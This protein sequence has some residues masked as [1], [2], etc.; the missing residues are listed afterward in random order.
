[1]VKHLPTIAMKK[2]QRLQMQ[3]SI[4]HTPLKKQLM[5]SLN[6]Q[7]TL[8]RFIMGTSFR[9]LLCSNESDPRFLMA[10]QAAKNAL[11]PIAETMSALVELKKQGKIRAIGVSNFSV[12]QI[13]EAMQFDPI[14]SVQP[15]YSLF[16]R[17]AADLL[18]PYS[19]GND[20]SILAYSPLAQG[21]LTGKFTHSHRFPE[22][23][24][25]SSHKLCL[26]EHY[27]RVQIALEKLR[28]IALKNAMTLG[29]LALTWL[30][31]QP[32][33][34]AIVG[35]RNPP[36]ILE[37]AAVLHMALS[38]YDLEEINAIGREVTNHLDA[39]PVMWL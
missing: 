22:G 8:L 10:Y 5:N 36:Q 17:Q 21:L 28:P 38:P 18:T 37:N 32:L 24:L 35:A 26:P 12:G 7:T 1:M 15:P 2:L 4:G 34:S 30:I 19:L 16:W 6:I 31:S 39:D 29:Q 14:V 11:V 9:L 13:E 20:L 3:W 27:A 25:R 23:E 33:T